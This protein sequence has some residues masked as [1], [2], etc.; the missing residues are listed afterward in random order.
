MNDEKEYSQGEQEADINLLL[1]VNRAATSD[2]GGENCVWCGNFIGACKEILA[3]G[4]RGTDFPS[5]T[6]DNKKP[7]LPQLSAQA[8]IK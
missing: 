1:C 2:S 4:V 3:R 6:F 5:I 7:R 8:K